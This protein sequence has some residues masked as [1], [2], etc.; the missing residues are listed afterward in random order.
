M[1]VGIKRIQDILYDDKI[2]SFEMVHKNYGEHVSWLDYYI[3]IS[4]IPKEWKHSLGHEQLN[5]QYQY[6]YDLLLNCPNH[7]QIVYTKFVSDTNLIEK[8]CTKWEIILRQPIELEKI[9]NHIKGIYSYM[10]R[11]KLRNF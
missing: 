2:M 7:T 10:V 9:F 8:Y 5:P 11:T 3:A 6:K 4:S 1:Q